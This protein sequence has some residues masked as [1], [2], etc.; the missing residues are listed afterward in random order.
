MAEKKPQRP[1]KKQIQALIKKEGK[2][3]T[4]FILRNKHE[5]TVKDIAEVLEV[6]QRTVNAYIWRVKEPE[7]YKR[8]LAKY[9]EKRK[10]RQEVEKMKEMARKTKG[11]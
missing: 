4:A 3:R 7:K 8:L 5:M 11:K 1:S 2:I 6:G 10:Q 9:F